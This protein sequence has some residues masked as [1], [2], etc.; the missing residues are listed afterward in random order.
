VGNTYKGQPV[1]K[2]F[3]QFRNDVTVLAGHYEMAVTLKGETR[4]TAKSISFGNMSQEEFEDLYN[5]TVDVILSR[6]MTSYS[7][8]DLDNVINQLLSFA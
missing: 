7:R 8:D 5:A 4:L 6:I 2:N 3:D 1:T